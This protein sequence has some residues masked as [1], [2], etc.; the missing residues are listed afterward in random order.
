M[1]YVTEK[2]IRYVLSQ[3]EFKT[4]KQI[5]ANI[6][7]SES[8]VKH[9]IAE[10]KM[11]LSKV[12]G[13]LLSVPGKGFILE[14][15]S[16]DIEILKDEV[17]K[18]INQSDSYVYR[19]N[20]I[21]NILFMKKSN[22]TIQIF[23]DDLGVSR[24]T[25]L[26][27]LESIEKWLDFYNIKLMRVR[28]F[29]LT[30]EGDE[31]DIREAIMDSNKQLMEFT[32]IDIDRPDNFDLRISKTFFNYFS[33]FY[34][35]SNLYNLQN[36]LKKA[37]ERLN[38][39]CA[40]AS[41]IQLI[42]YLAILKRRVNEGNIIVK[43]NILSKYKS[44][45]VEYSVAKDLIY[46]LFPITEKFLTMEIHCLAIQFTLYGCYDR[47]SRGVYEEEYYIGLAVT[48]LK[49][50]QN[51]A[52]IEMSLTDDMITNIANLF[53]KKQIRESYQPVPNKYLINDI[54][55]NLSSIYGVVLANMR[56]MEDSFHFTVK[57]TDVAYIAMLIDNAKIEKK[58]LV[59]TLF[60]TS[61]D[62]NISVY[63]KNKIERNVHNIS[64]I[65][66]ME[67]EDYNVES[68]KDYDLVLT[69]VLM[70]NQTPIKISRRVDQVDL[71]R[72]QRA[73]NEKIQNRYRMTIYKQSLFDENLILVNHIFKKK[74]D[75]IKAGCALLEKFNYVTKDFYNVLIERENIV[76]TTIGKGIAMPHGFK[77][78]VLKSGVAIIKLKNPLE[79]NEKDKVDLIFIF[80]INL[81]NRKEVMTL[82]QNFY[83][84]V[85][86]DG[87][88]INIKNS[89]TSAELLEYIK[90]A[91]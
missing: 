41:F 5:A 13:K 88:L 53:I 17:F 56:L 71:D 22:Y 61:F 70:D 48:L 26:Y 84:L 11:I 7:V 58:E 85:S 64:I 57:D 43:K 1:E 2:I 21:L 66:I 81:D 10:A 34:S 28:N 75:A 27:D 73:V 40:D 80:A 30:V 14:S 54:K 35:D 62:K 79:W 23:A 37:E 29:G 49:N 9:N 15:S 50:I 86:E 4:A 25:I 42:E 38:T 33:K 44:S 36:L 87:N 77:K 52:Q 91:E 24:N 83:R 6:N 89:T 12:G 65:K 3:N 69:T 60:I 67:F 20:Y 8:S 68:F 31:F 19:Q 78:G 18:L 39:H 90:N 46:T 59:K 63:L 51:V 16:S 32:S 74:E 76:P 82:F 72:I 47:A 45:Y 55:T